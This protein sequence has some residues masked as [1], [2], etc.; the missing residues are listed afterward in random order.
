MTRHVVDVVCADT[1]RDITGMLNEVADRY[2]LDAA[3]LLAGAIAESNIR[4]QAARNGTWPDVS[5]GLYQEAVKWLAPEASGGPAGL[6]RLTDGT[7]VDTPTNRAIARAWAFDASNQLDYVAPRYRSLLDRAGG[8]PLLAWCLWNAPG[9]DWAHPDPQHALNKASYQRALDRAEEYVGAMVDDDLVRWIGDTQ[10]FGPVD[11]RGRLPV[12][13]QYGHYDPR[14]LADVEGVTIHYTA[15]PLGQSVD[16]IAAYQIS[17]AAAGQT[18]TGHPF[19]AIAYHLVVDGAGN[20][21]YCNDLDTV[22]WHKPGRNDTYVG[23]CF[24][25]TG[26]PTDAQLDGLA[27][28]ILWAGAFVGRPLA[29]EGHKDGYATACPGA[30]WPGWRPMLDHAIERATGGGDVDLDFTGGHQVS[31]PFIDFM[32]AHPEYGVARFDEER[33]KYGTLL[34]TTPTDA[35][36]K[37]S[38]LVY[39]EWL[40]AVAVATW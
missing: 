2:H 10:T 19:P 33:T 38:L 30:G 28:A 35:Y 8:D 1:N 17:L 3:W 18:G 37:G 39:R 15:G 14:S 16:A 40:K 5:Y 7:V 24:T 20:V 21:H 11:D 12:A 29:I 25:G 6:T 4:E 22:T 26:N 31:R 9:L 23:L 34:W 32:R 27:K 36:R 13:P